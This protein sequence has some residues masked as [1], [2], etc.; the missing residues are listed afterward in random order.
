LWSGITQGGIYKWTFFSNPSSQLDFFS[1]NE[2]KGSNP[3]IYDIN[4]LIAIKIIFFL[5]SNPIVA[6][7]KE[8][9]IIY[10]RY[11]GGA[12]LLAKLLSANKKQL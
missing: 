10:F 12:I 6:V 11:K 3:Q 9:V 2:A 8:M 5:F 7:R 4:I 1:G